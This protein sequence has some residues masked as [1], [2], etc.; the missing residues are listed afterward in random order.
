MTTLKLHSMDEIRQQL[1]NQLS[2]LPDDAVV[3]FGAGDLQLYRVKHRGERDGHPIVQVE[4][5]EVYT[6]TLDPA[7]DA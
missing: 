6:V 7:A 1:L 2:G 4:F 3:Y 5:N